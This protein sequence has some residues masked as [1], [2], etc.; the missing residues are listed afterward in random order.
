MVLLLLFVLFRSCT[1]LLTFSDSESVLVL[2]QLW[3]RKYCAAAHK[4]THCVFLLA[5]WCFVSHAPWFFLISV[6]SLLKTWN[7]WLPLTTWPQTNVLT[8]A[9]ISK[10]GICYQALI[11]DHKMFFFLLVRMLIHRLKSFCATI[12]SESWPSLVLHLLVF[13]SLY[14]V[15]V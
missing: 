7:I 4:Q 6:S 10:R 15:N 13:V 9:I 8:V 11:R 3:S 5:R 1:Q 14:F 2:K 12:Y